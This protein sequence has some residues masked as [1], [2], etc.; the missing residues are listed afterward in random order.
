MGKAA[1]I[2]RLLS[3]F[4]RDRGFLHAPVEFALAL[5]ADDQIVGGLIGNTNWDWLH[6]EVLAIDQ[7]YRRFTE[8]L[9]KEKGCVGAWVDTFRSRRPGSTNTL[10][11]ASSERCHPIQTKSSGFSTRSFFSAEHRLASAASRRYRLYC[12]MPSAFSIA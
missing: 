2:V 7:R 11:I 4:S 10:D 12:S 8:M 6:I 9:A 5:L 1:A 3:E